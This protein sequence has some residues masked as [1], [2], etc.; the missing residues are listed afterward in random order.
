MMEKNWK[1]III[2]DTHIGSNHCRAGKLLKFL[3]NHQAE[4]YFLNGDIIDFTEISR[5][6]GYWNKK[7]TRILKKLIQISEQFN[8]IYV[9]GNHEKM[10]RPYLPFNIGNIKV[11]S[12]YLYEGVDKRKYHISHG[13]NIKVENSQISTLAGDMLYQLLLKADDVYS[14]MRG[15]EEREE[16][17]A[18]FVKENLKAVEIRSLN[19]MA[20]AIEKK[21]QE[22][23]VV[24]HGHIHMA[25]VA[26]K[27]MN[28]G[29]FSEGAT[30][31]VEDFSG[32]WSIVRIS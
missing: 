23:D 32:L 2:S 31:L 22:C 16:S 15:D 10:F 19:Y 13:D 4:T 21:P 29:D 26:E 5:G 12:S 20:K 11:V 30:A 8:V 18:Q 27:Y 6:R 25:H 1:T 9:L 7:Y 14:F 28:S 3:E 24:V 17:L